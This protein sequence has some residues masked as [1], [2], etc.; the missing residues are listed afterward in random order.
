MPRVIEVS[1]LNFPALSTSRLKLRA[2]APDDVA[3]FRGL[4]SIPEVARYSNW[5]KDPN[6][7]QANEWTRTLAELFPSGKGCAWV[8]EERSSGAFV[9]AVHFNY[10]Y[11]EWRLGGVGYETHPTYWGR[12]LTTEAL[13]AVVAYGHRYLALNRIEAWTLPGNDA[14][15]RVLKKAGFQ[16]EGVFRQKGFFKGA[17]HDFRMFGRVASDAVMHAPARSDR[18]VAAERGAGERRDKRVDI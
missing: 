8:I 14:S 9:G 10:F 5:P 7:N 3:E 1:T 2:I 12:G 4:M 17:F 16:F 13:R 15:D 11:W 18:P 6:E